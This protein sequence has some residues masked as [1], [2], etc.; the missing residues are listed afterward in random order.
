M[1]SI[2]EDTLPALSVREPYA[3]AIFTHKKLVE[4]RTRRFHHRGPLVVHASGFYQARAF[5]ADIAW[6]ERHI[7]IPRSRLEA[8]R[9]APRGGLIGIVRVVDCVDHSPS[10]WFTGPH[11]LVLSDPVE[12]EF[13]PWR[14][15]LGLFRVPRQALKFR[16]RRRSI[17]G[18]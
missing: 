15:R 10:R 16:R 9:H 17:S 5:D 12:V 8:L 13:C 6:I 2:D 18:D 14:G 1:R 4:N 7:G 11:A 3:T